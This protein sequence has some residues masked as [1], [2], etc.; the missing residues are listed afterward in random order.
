MILSAFRRSDHNRNIQGLY[1][2][3]VAQAR[4]PA[5]YTHYGVADSVEGRF[6]LI[7]LHLVL[8]L[9]RL[10][11][12]QVAIPRRGLARSSGQTIRQQ[13]FDVF[14]RDLDDNLREMGVGDLAV[15]RKM[16]K[17]GEAFYG[18]QAAYGAALAA[19]DPRELEKALAR[20]ILGEAE[21]GEKGAQLA[22]YM[23]A[24]TT[25]LDAQSEDALIAGKAAFPSPEIF[26]NA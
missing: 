24:A 25:Q 9:R 17:F 18:R 26:V 3:I 22:R 6:E 8:V 20:N 10:S 15:P 2:A 7:V 12:E 19:A 21:A 11:G 5:F 16:R 13:L 23:R 1:G 4:L 14:C